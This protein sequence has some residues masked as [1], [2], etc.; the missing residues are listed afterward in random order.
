MGGES[1][2]WTFP[3]GLIVGKQVLFEGSWVEAPKYDNQKGSGIVLEVTES[4]VTVNLTEGEA[5]HLTFR[6][7]EE[8]LRYNDFQVAEGRLPESGAEQNA[9]VH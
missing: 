5:S 8:H 7:G 3:E 4:G 2:T 9:T 1:K 6:T